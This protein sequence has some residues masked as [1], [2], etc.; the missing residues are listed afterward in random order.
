M[1]EMYEIVWFKIWVL[2]LHVMLNVHHVWGQTH[3]F[4]RCQILKRCWMSRSAHPA[5][6]VHF[7]YPLVIEHSYG[8]SPFF[9]GN[10]TIS[11]AIFNSKLLNYQRILG[12]SFNIFDMGSGWI[13]NIM[14]TWADHHLVDLADV[15][16]HA[17]EDSQQYMDKPPTYR[18]P[19]H[20]HNILYESLWYIPCILC[21]YHMSRLFI[22]II[23]GESTIWNILEL[24][25]VDGDS[26]CIFQ[27]FGS[28][29][30]GA[31][32]LFSTSP[33]A[34]VEV[35]SDLPYVSNMFYLRRC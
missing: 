7:G 33:S 16:D 25:T 26:T 30:T 9:M 3:D 13:R 23:V 5:R 22:P 10:S 29:A 27:A 32:F 6:L 14:R 4:R 20:I 35:S 2:P 12:E 17:M 19:L 11:M 1:Y 24:G 8:K 15:L 21:I 31:D 34:K 18:I 28:K